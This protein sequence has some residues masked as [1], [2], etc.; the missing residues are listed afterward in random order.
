[1]DKQELL[2]QVEDIE[3]QQ[4]LSKQNFHRCEGAIALLKRQ[5]KDLEDKEKK[6]TEEKEVVKKKET[7]NGG[8][9]KG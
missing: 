7:T 6:D 1:M 2:K 4:E 9:D 5:I 8:D 3:R